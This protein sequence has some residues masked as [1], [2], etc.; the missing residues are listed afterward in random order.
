MSV[1]KNKELIEKLCREFDI[2][3]LYAFGSRSHEVLEFFEND[4][5]KLS[6]S[7]SDVDIG[8]R[9]MEGKR[10]DIQEKVQLA[11]KLEDLFA[12]NRVDLVS[13]SEADPFLAVEII[14][15]E[16]IFTRDEF[17]ADEYELYLLRRAGDLIPLER[18][19]QRLI[20]KED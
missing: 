3:I 19:R 2:D 10:L 9:L 16:R 15:G 5:P 6:T 4:A 7:G 12:V 17:R 20:F 1:G 8:I 13:L 14:R 18:E 11:I